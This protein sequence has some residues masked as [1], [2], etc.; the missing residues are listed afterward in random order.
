MA[1]AAST[2]AESSFASIHDSMSTSSWDTPTCISTT[3]RSSGF[4]TVPG[5]SAQVSAAPGNTSL[6]AGFLPGSAPSTTPERVSNAVAIRQRGAGS[7]VFDP[8]RVEMVR[9]GA[10][11]IL[12]LLAFPHPVRR[13]SGRRGGGASQLT[14]PCRRQDRAAIRC[15]PR[16]PREVSEPV[17]SHNH[18][19]PTRS[20]SHRRNHPSRRSIG[21]LAQGW[22][23]TRGR[24]LARLPLVRPHVGQSGLAASRSLHL[25]HTGP[26]RAWALAQRGR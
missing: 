9:A 5:R 16:D 21:S 4:A 25:L 18:G 22:K 20:C 26:D 14:C 3:A 10:Q 24:S 13:R 6:L 17:V 2:R 8:G 1:I 11:L 15:T 7:L 12:R 19:T 23:R